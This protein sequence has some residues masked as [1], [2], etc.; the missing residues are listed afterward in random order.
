MPDEWC[1][2]VGR[3]AL[4]GQ[5][6]RLAAIAAVI[7]NMNEKRRGIRAPAIVPSERHTL[8]R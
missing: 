1:D 2:L 4:D 5:G 6:E 7:L 3:I 8:W